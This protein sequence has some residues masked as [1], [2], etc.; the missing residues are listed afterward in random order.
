[1]EYVNAGHTEGLIVQPGGKVD[2]LKSTCPCVSPVTADCSWE[3]RTTDFPNDS[4]LLLYTDG[5][6]EAWHDNV[7]FG[8]D[9]FYEL[10]RKR[11]AQREELIPSISGG[12]EAFLQGDPR[13]DDITLLSAWRSDS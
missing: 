6:I 8:P 4:V 13:T 2:P 10:V 12:L 1:M 5:I 3:C 11:A 7:M 9:R